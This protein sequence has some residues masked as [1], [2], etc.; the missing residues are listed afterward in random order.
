VTAVFF[1]NGSVD[2]GALV[3]VETAVLELNAGALVEAEGE[4]VAGAMGG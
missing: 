2:A 4:F 1:S 3:T